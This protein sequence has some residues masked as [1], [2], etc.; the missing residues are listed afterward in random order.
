M[1]LNSINA[2][3]RYADSRAA[4]QPSGESGGSVFQNAVADFAQ[5]LAEG[6]VQA[7]QAMTGDADPVSY[8]HLTLPTI[9]LV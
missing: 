8:T 1:D 2:T 5:T 6:E 4:T 7:K 3:Q 9:L